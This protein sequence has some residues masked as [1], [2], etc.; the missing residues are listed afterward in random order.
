M[1]KAYNAA[2]ECVAMSGR[3]DNLAFHLERLDRYGVVP[4]AEV[5]RVERERGEVPPAIGWPW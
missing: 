1:W 2:G 4:A 3:L 5:V